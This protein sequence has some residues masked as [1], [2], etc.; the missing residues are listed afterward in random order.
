MHSIPCRSF[1]KTITYTHTLPY[2]QLTPNPHPA[3]PSAAACRNHVAKSMH[4]TALTYLI[5]ALGTIFNTHTHIPSYTYIY[6]LAILILQRDKKRTTT[7]AAATKTGSTIIPIHSHYNSTTASHHFNSLS[8]PPP[9]NSNHHPANVFCPS[10]T[11]T[12]KYPNS[13][14]SQAIT[15][16]IQLDLPISFAYT[17][18]TKHSI[19]QHPLSK[20]VHSNTQHNRL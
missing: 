3:A 7:A 13:H 16:N 19:T 2:Q 10:T 15:Q 17:R 11:S 5:T 12:T 20:L 9:P 4:C 1:R 18:S 6:S 14:P 8:C